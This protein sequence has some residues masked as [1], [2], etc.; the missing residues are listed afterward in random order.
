MGE[1][2]VLSAEFEKKLHPEARKVF[3]NWN[4]DVQRQVQLAELNNDDLKYLS[5]DDRTKLKRI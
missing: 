5:D 3:H 2:I 4:A 1:L